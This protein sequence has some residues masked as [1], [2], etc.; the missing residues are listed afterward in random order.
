MVKQKKNLDEL[1]SRKYYDKISGHTLQAVKTES[2]GPTTDAAQQHILRIHYQISEWR[3]NSSFEPLDW[4]WR[5]T[6]GGK[7]MP[8]EMT[9]P[10]APVEL[11][12]SLKCGCKT[13]CSRKNCTCKQYGVKC[14]NMCTACRGVSCMNCEEISNSDA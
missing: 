12:K 11:L 3:G 2:L 8:I 4:G 1:R 5:L 7:L 9:K 13:D 10:N 14:T 6:S